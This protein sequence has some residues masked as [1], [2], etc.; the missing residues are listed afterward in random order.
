MTEKI[1]LLKMGLL[2]RRNRMDERSREKKERKKESYPIG[3]GYG[4]LDEP[5]RP[6]LEGRPPIEP[7]APLEK[8]GQVSP[9]VQAAEGGGGG[10]E[11]GGGWGWRGGEAHG[12]WFGICGFAV[13]DL[14]QQASLLVVVVVPRFQGC[15]CQ[16]WLLLLVVV[17]FNLV[18]RSPVKDSSFKGL[19]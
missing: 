11:D 1:G 12:W 2:T 5:D 10:G 6:G 3:S 19:L 17:L 4:A 8:P 18:F 16:L 15:C 9:R 7:C 13:N 14:G